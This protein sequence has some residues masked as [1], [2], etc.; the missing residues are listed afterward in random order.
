MHLLTLSTLIV[1]ATLTVLIG[2]TP[3]QGNITDLRPE[4]QERLSSSKV[5]IKKTI[6]TPLGTMIP[7]ASSCES[8]TRDN[9]DGPNEC[10]LNAGLERA[11]KFE[12]HTSVSNFATDR[13]DPK[14]PRNRTAGHP[15]VR[16]KPLKTISVENDQVKMIEYNGIPPL[17]FYRYYRLNMVGVPWIGQDLY[18]FQMEPK[19]HPGQ[20]ITSWGVKDSTQYPYADLTLSNCD[21]PN[22]PEGDDLT[23]QNSTTTD[24][25]RQ[26][27]STHFVETLDGKSRGHLN[28]VGDLM[29]G[30]W[31]CADSLGRSARCE[32]IDSQVWDNRP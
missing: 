1:L 7:E 8:A 11:D 31:T 28:G 4:L 24:P 21:T 6:K 19:D 23:M 9:D 10:D 16:S 25:V 12:Y 15:V 32:D 13:T 18:T 30:Y 27:L 2:Q 14:D 20:C 22:L 3:V 29:S 5:I 26:W 17:Y